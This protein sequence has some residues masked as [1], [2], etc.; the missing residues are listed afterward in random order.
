MRKSPRFWERTFASLGFVRRKNKKPRSRP[1]AGR[2]LRIE[3]LDEREMLSGAQPMAPLTTLYW[4]P[5]HTKT[6]TAGGNGTWD[7]T[8]ANWYNAATNQ[9]VVYNSLAPSVVF[10]GPAGIVTVSGTITVKQ[11]TINT[12]SGLSYG[13]TFGGGGLLESPNMGLTINIGAGSATINSALQI[14]GNYGVTKTGA[15]DI[16]S[17]LRWRQLCQHDRFDGHFGGKIQRLSA[18][19]QCR[20]G[21]EQRDS[22]RDGWWN[23]RMAVI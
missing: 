19:L 7:T 4:D 2:P 20:L 14:N 16:D 9:D 6:T 11:I 18:S 17:R 10:Q 3:K 12:N 15:R 13:Y 8:T 22:R 23:R 1:R 21:F 5:N